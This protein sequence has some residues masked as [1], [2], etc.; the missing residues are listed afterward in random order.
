MQKI[1]WAKV[2]DAAEAGGTGQAGGGR[3]TLE[4][5]I[6]NRYEVMASLCPWIRRGPQGRNRDPCQGRQNDL[7]LLKNRPSAGC[8]DVDRRSRQ[9]QGWQ[10]GRAAGTPVPRQD[11]GHARGASCGSTPASRVNSWPPTCRPGASRAE[12]EAASPRCAASFG[13]LR[14]HVR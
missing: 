6:A 3:E 13:R 14:A 5:L 1:G 11:G 10:P 8:R 4:A 7:S 12:D 2:K 9:R